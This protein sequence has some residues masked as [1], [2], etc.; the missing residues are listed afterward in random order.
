MRLS[1]RTRYFAAAMIPVVAAVAVLDVALSRQARDEIEAEARLTLTRIIAFASSELPGAGSS[2][3]DLQRFAR[4]VGASD[5]RVTIIAR[6][7]KVLADSAIADD[8]VASMQDHSD[9][10]EF[11]QALAEGGGT[12]VRYSATLDTHLMYVARRVDLPAGAVV[13]RLALPMVRLEAESRERRTALGIALAASLAIA[14][15]GVWFSTAVLTRRVRRLS[16]AATMMAGGWDGVPVDANRGD[17]LAVL[18]RALSD[19]ARSNRE[20]LD[21]LAAEGRRVRTILDAMREGV[22]AVGADGR[23]TLVNRAMLALAGL[24]EAPSDARPADLFRVPELLEAIDAALAGRS[25]SRETQ[26]SHPGPATLLVDA[27]PIPDGGGAVVVLHDTTEVHRLHQVRRDFVANVSHELRNPIA[28]VQAAA[29][30]LA[31]LGEGEIEDQRRLVDTISRQ[32]ERM[33]ALVRDLLDLARVEAGQYPM[34]PEDTDLR[35]LVEAA[36][37]SIAPRA[38]AKSLTVSSDP[39]PDGLRCRCDPAALATVLANLLDNAVKYTRTGDRLDVRVRRAGDEVE[40]EVAD[41]GPG[42]E[43]VHLPRLFER[44]Y[45]VDTGRSRDLGGTG[46]GLAIVKHLVQ[47]MGGTVRVRSAVG[48]GT[49]FTV[50]LPAMH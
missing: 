8:A 17:E 50:V 26:V 48:R 11:V 43:E 33:G 16:A 40:I 4:A 10:P 3:G 39:G 42:I 37:A 12:A 15:A 46:L 9:R 22:M 21:R 31:V 35:P 25:M 7:G 29:E 1:F 47:A 38:S 32:S 5:A 34:R 13:L 36:M 30:T 23:V 14:A 2:P 6:D 41:T 49:V 28:T 27:A 45:R 44:F 19:L 20:S 24:P 18:A